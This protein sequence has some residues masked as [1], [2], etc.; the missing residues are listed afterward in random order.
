MS[1]LSGVGAPTKE[2][3]GNVGDI[4]TDTSTAKKY[5]CVLSYSH[6]DSYTKTETMFYKWWAMP[7]E[8]DASDTVESPYVKETY[9]MNGNLIAAE[10]VGVDKIRSYLFYSLTKM[11][12]VSLPSGL[13]GIGGYA[14]KDC[15]SLALTSLPSGLTSIGTY[16]FQ[17]CSSLALTSLPSGIISIG[18]DAFHG[19]SK[20]ALTSLPSDLTTISSFAFYG[21]SSLALTRFPSGIKNIN[22]Y[23]FYGCSN[24]LSL[25]FEGTPTKISSVAFNACSKLKTINV[26]WAEGAVANAPWGATKATINYDYT[27]E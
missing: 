12:S 24:L 10:V 17:G 21:C 3:V 1:E 23:A 4:Y 7:S 25:T 14:F 26:P 8:D 18:S 16:A 27:G 20:M 15:S 19:C 9:D 5:K 6:K 22:D 2:T 13:T 11:T